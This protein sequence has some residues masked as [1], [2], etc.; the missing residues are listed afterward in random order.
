MSKAV[1]SLLWWIIAGTKGGVT[2][3]KIILALKER[4]LTAN[5]L[6]NLLR[7]DYKTIRYHLDLLTE[8]ELLTTVGRKYG[9]MYFISPKLE[10][11]FKVFLEIW[12]KISKEKE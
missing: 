8:N 12:K 11:N 2:R 9:R 6:S 5:Q 1:S 10:S 3:A 7:L 4:P